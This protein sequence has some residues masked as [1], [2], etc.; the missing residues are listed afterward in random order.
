MQELFIAIIKWPIDPVNKVINLNSFPAFKPII[1]RFNDLKVTVLLIQISKY[2][3]Q[4]K[5]TTGNLFTDNKF[6]Q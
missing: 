5:L 1:K 2:T 4:L 6:K 3:L